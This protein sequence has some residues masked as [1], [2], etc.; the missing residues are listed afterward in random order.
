MQRFDRESVPPPPVLSG[1]EANGARHHFL[2]FMLLPAER[3]SQTRYS[4][5]PLQLG[6]DPGL[7]AALAKLFY[8]KCAFCEAKAPTRPYHFRPAGE[9]H[10]AGRETDAHL[11]YVW[12][13]TAWQN[14][15]PICSSCEPNDPLYFPV[16]GS[17]CPIPGIAALQ[18]F[19][20]EGD[21]T[22][23]LSIKESP[24]LLDPCGAKDF[25]S[26]LGA[27]LKGMLT[28]QSI[29]GETTIEHFNLNRAERVTGRMLRYGDYWTKLLNA[30]AD[31][32]PE[33]VDQ[34]MAFKELEFGGSWYLLLRGAVRELASLLKES[35]PPPSRW[36]EFLQGVADRSDS[37]DLLNRAIRAEGTPVNAVD[38]QK[39]P[40]APRH[41]D[42]ARVVSVK[43]SNFKAIENLE[44][45]L[46]SVDATS[47][48]LSGEQPAPSLLV[49][50]ENAA[51][52][53]SILEAIALTLSEDA[54]RE[55]LREKT[56]YQHWVLNPKFFGRSEAG[57]REATVE[58]ELSNG[59]VRS[60]KISGHQFEDSD[61]GDWHRIPV[62][63]Y[64]AFRQFNQKHSSSGADR[65]VRNLFA[66]TELPNPEKWLLG[67]PDERFNM[68]IRALREILA[69]E[70]EFDVVERDFQ[71]NECLVVTCVQGGD[72]QV[73][74]PLY[75]V[76]SGFRS[77][78][79]M[80]CDVMSGLMNR[81]TYPGFGSLFTARGMVLIDEVEAHLHPRWKMRIM[82]GLRR[83]LPQI[84]FIATSH[85]PLCLRGMEDGEV[86]V[87]Q[88]VVGID[89]AAQTDLPV[90]VESLQRLPNVSQLRVDQL[91]TSDFFQLYS[92][93]APEFEETMAKM[94]DLLTRAPD[95][96]TL[97]ERAALESYRRDLAE[98]LPIGSTEAHR[99]AQ[100]AVADYLEAR[101]SVSQ[102]RADSL[103]QAAKA[104]IVAALEGR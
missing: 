96:L 11:Y 88:R 43:V 34:M 8:G 24:R 3:R 12:L 16:L 42:T 90:F 78:L 60:L 38:A 69:I 21:G 36:R 67:L 79:A 10:P 20:N 28:P 58:I 59:A 63:A 57:P 92:T 32:S 48:M 13:E 64:G 55:R 66:G 102:Q 94:S 35:S 68:V 72:A 86:I 23:W 98:A 26:D 89:A 91:L 31:G 65:H 18:R 85:D 40:S 83:A 100:E 75:A 47:D 45:R 14:L 41:V 95:S 19:A 74:T 93:D 30:L 22:W 1:S 87:L 97:D 76:S 15:L 104:R 62:F 73:R 61:S 27:N 70:G 6:S 56:D 50:G 81:T 29:R 82:Q 71:S 51:G 80:A 101:R 44:V 77:V 5:T 54:S 7:H 2:K 17:R 53:S 25:H 49:L 103:R 37:V 84:T 39:A 99:V 33:G 4:S 9:A 46:P 52:K